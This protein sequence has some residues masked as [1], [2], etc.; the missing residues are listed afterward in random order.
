LVWYEL[1]AISLILIG[2][3][4][5]FVGYNV[6]G[7]GM[8]ALNVVAAV[9]IVVAR[10]GQQVQLVEALALI[11]VSRVVSFILASVSIIYSISVVLVL[12]WR[13]ILVIPTVSLYLL[14]AANGLMLIPITT[15]IAHQKLNRLDL[16]LTGGLRLIY[17][18]PF[19][20]LIGAGLGFIEYAILGNQAA[21]PSVFTSELIRLSIIMIFFVALVE[22]L[23]FRVLI[24]SQLIDRSGAVAGILITSVLFGSLHAI[25]A[26]PY[27]LLF[28]T[29]AGVIFGVSFFKTKSL[30]FVVTM[31][32][33]DDI[34]LFGL[35][36]FLPL[37]LP[38]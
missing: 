27:E 21:I 1:F 33:V 19:G 17:L 7:A 12:C 14:V 28:T 6:L 36:P 30:P 37:A 26:N 9:V 18:I 5:L 13:L 10:R 11:S 35:L 23:I 24:Q 20:I 2:E 3:G 29:L 32:A 22:E 31:H 25:Y 4:L 34:F 8:H 38:H 15:I 16:G